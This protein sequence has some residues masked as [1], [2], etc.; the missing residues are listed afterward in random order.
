M[1][2]GKTLMLLSTVGLGI[3]L[4]G[5]I[6]VMRRIRQQALATC[7]ETYTNLCG[8]SHDILRM[9]SDK[10]YLHACFCERRSLDSSRQH[11]VDCLICCETIANYID[12]AL[13]QKENMPETVFNKWLFPRQSVGMSVVLRDF[14]ETYSGWHAPEMASICKEIRHEERFAA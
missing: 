10:P 4:F 8:L 6:F 7:G 14:S 5:F 11:K 2:P 3:N 13:S 1:T 12:N 9:I